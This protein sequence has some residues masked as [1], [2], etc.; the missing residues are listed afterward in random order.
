MNQSTQ[1]IL[2]PLQLS[3][4]FWD[5]LSPKGELQPIVKLGTRNLRFSPDGLKNLTS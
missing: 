2:S 1:S 3:V 4:D 5:M